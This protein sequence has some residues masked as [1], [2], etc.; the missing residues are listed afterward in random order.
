MWVSFH[1]FFR[2]EEN[3]DK[4]SSSQPSLRVRSSASPLLVVGIS[5]V[6]FDLFQ[7]VFEELLST[8][9]GELWEYSP[10]GTPSCGCPTGLLDKLL[11]YPNK[12]VPEG[13][14]GADPAVTPAA[15]GDGS[16]AQSPSAE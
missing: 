8:W 7:R 5:L 9:E 15:P 2:A 6:D 12:K 3:R 1:P 4:L 14:A 10:V 16:A 11:V 13:R